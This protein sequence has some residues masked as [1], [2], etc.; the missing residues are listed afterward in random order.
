[1]QERDRKKG[2]EVKK[3]GRRK[4]AMIQIKLQVERKE[5]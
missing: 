4:V 1:V 3:K 5:N 2:K